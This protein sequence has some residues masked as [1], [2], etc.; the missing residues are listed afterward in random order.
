[1]IVV[2]GGGPA[3]RYAAMRLAG[4]G[5]E[6]LLVDRRSEGLGGQC[7]HQGCM[8][9]CALNDMART[10]EQMD[11]LHRSGVITSVPVPDYS[12]LMA[13]MREII[14]IIARVIAEETSTAGVKKIYG[15]A[16]VEGRTVFIDDER[17]EP[18]AVIIATGTHPRRLN[19]PGEDLP[20][21]ETSQSIFTLPALPKKLIIIGGGV[22][23][24]E[25][26][27]IYS[28]LGSEVTILARTTLL[29]E[30]PKILVKEAK[31]E[32]HRVTIHEQA[33]V[34]RIMGDSRVSGVEIRTPEGTRVIEA[35]TVLVAAGTKA[36]VSAISG[37]PLTPNG[38]I[39]VNE[40]ME[41]GVQGVYAV[42]DVTGTSSLTP[43]ARW[44]GRTAADIILGGEPPA[45]LI[46]VPQAIK[47]RND[48]AFCGIHNQGGLK[49]TITSPAGPGSFWAIPD[50]ATGKASM[51]ADPDSGE[52]LGMAEASPYASVIAAYHALLI[53]AG[54]SIDQ[55]ERFIEVH[56]SADGAGWIGRYL[57]ETIAEKKTGRD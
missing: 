30:L 53:N 34:I 28:L 46:T 3:G 44:Q 26:A 47:L 51:T 29:K 42:G 18:E 25:V 6:V 52:I 33:A 10:M 32:L 43:V 13:K 31:R 22:I 8:V 11:T 5:K 56:P 24:A 4:A 50:R 40:K 9:I 41:T 37:V 21:V 7:L 20:G 12:A 16:R 55:M 57:A 27:Y 39:M 14:S 15:E 36:E 48:L 49:V 54:L 2:V 19:I 45:P 23:T 1:M 35:D 17:L 38:F